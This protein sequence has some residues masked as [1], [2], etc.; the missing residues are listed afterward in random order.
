LHNQDHFVQYSVKKKLGQGF[1]GFFLNSSKSP[2]FWFM[3]FTG[4]LIYEMVYGRT[5][6]RGKNRQTTFTN[7]LEKD[8]LFPANIPVSKLH[9][10]QHS[11]SPVEESLY[12]VS[13]I[14]SLAFQF[15][16]LILI[17]LNLFWHMSTRSVWR[18]DS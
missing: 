13:M 9:A 3:S 10:Q 5:P 7:I 17:M 6:F 8:L 15:I 2:Q 1:F 14:S 18:E 11:I 16:P 4:V 12:F